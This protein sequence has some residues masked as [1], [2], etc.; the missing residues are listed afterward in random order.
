MKSLLSIVLLA[1]LAFAQTSAPAPTTDK[2]KEEAKSGC[3]GGS[4]GG[5]CGAKDSKDKKDAKKSGCC[6]EAK[7]G[8]MCSRQKL[9]DDKPAEPKK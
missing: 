6:G 7:D 3:C 5:C 8:A 4:G 1:G 9:K 2:P